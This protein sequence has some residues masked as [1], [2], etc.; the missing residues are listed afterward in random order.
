MT[1]WRCR[2]CGMTQPTINPSDEEL[3]R[4]LECCP[5]CGAQDAHYEDFLE[6]HNAYCLNPDDFEDDIGDDEFDDEVDELVD[7]MLTGTFS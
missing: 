4:L 3:E 2:Y 1:F 7:E 6:G 5:G